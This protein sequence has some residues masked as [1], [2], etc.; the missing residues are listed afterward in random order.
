MPREPLCA[1]MAVAA[2][3]GFFAEE[4]LEVEIDRSYPSGKRALAGLLDGQID[5][6]ATAEAPL[7]FRSFERD[8]FRVVATIGSS[9]NEAK[10]VARADA[11]VRV[12]A[13]L[14]GKRIATQRGSAVHYFLHLFLLR[15]GMSEADVELSYLKA[16]QLAPALA[17]GEID[18]FSMREPFVGEAKKLLGDQAVELAEAGLYVKTFNLVAA[19]DVLQQRPAAVEAAVR[20]LVR[21][22]RFVLEHPDEAR[23]LVAEQLEVDPQML[24][25][26]WEEIDL[27]VSLGQELL[28][29]LEGEARWAISGGLTESDSMPNY[30]ELIDPGCL[31]RVRPTSV[32]MIH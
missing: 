1:L 28:S 20:A 5:L 29:G 10:M 6:T 13:D 27:R 16:E 4:G 14:R 8:D 32:T 21:A 31:S 3:K 26:A 11:G 17:A 23:R 9:D 7:V 30:L 18:A 15:H 25:A 24:Q 12:P 19:A 2:G 22:E